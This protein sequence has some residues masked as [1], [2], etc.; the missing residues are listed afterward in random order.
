[1]SIK[2]KWIR[3][4]ELADAAK[5]SG[6]RWITPEYGV[7][8]WLRGMFGKPLAKSDVEDPEFQRNLETQIEYD[9][10]PEN[11][12]VFDRD[13]EQ[14]EKAQAPSPQEVIEAQAQ[15]EAQ[16]RAD[17]LHKTR[18][19]PAAR[20]GAFTDEQRWQQ[21]LKHR[22]WQM[23]N[24]RGPYRVKDDPNTPNNEAKEAARKARFNRRNERLVEKGL[25]PIEWKPR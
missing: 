14:M 22:E 10:K 2:D 16:Q 8:E 1:M 25:K 6:R 12:H 5:A 13:F 15:A 18:N 7:G 4:T 19:S 23:K 24:N 3:A 9:V 21:Q 11:R 20:S 17:W